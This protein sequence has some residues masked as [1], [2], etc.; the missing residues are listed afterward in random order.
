M[1]KFT[2]IF[3]WALIVVA[4]LVITSVLLSIETDND[5]AEKFC[6]ERNM[7]FKTRGGFRPTTYF[8]TWIEDD[9]FKEVEIKSVGRSWGFV[10]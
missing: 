10:E 5:R 1:R 9:V 3:T 8:C 4:M 6:E 2:I 7:N